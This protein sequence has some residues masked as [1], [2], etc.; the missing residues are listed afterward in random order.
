[1]PLGPNPNPGLGFLASVLRCLPKPSRLR[2]PESHLGVHLPNKKKLC[3]L[4]L[5][6]TLNEGEI[7]MPHED[8]PNFSR[9]TGY[10]PST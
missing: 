6:R 8:T 7:C 4:E 1:M 3:H 10:K 2:T 5:C 9:C